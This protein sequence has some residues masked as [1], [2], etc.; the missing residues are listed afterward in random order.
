[1]IKKNIG[2]ISRSV[3]CLERVRGVRGS[4]ELRKRV[5]PDNTMPADYYVSMMVQKGDFQ[6]PGNMQQFT[7]K[8]GASTV[9]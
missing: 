4:R 9:R 6:Q 7:L 8:P 1:M 5:N 2:I 3:D